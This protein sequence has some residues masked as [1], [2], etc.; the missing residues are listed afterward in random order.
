[1]THQP[2]VDPERWHAR[3]L[4]DQ[5]GNVSSEIGRAIRAREH[6]PDRFAA[7]LGRSLEL[8]DLTLDDPR[9]QGARRR[10]IARAREVACDFL[11]GPN[12]YGSTSE[13]V[14]AYF[15]AFAV[16]ARRDR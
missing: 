16:A 5:L 7:A 15:F 13:S 2:R 1:M 11:V 4:V 6:D 3:P 14:A 8:L 10:E 12:Q 9:W